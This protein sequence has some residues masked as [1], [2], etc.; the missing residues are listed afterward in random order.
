VAIQRVTANLLRFKE[1]DPK[2]TFKI[3]KSFEGP[4]PVFRLSGRAKIDQLDE[5]RSL[6]STKT[7][8]AILDLKELRLVDRGVVEFLSLCEAEGIELRNCPPYIREWILVDN[9]T[10]INHVPQ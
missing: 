8:M 2:M 7:R 6:F 5:I 10:R 9:K 3:E 4:K 1:G